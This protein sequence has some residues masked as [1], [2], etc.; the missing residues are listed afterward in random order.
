MRQW[1]HLPRFLSPK[2]TLLL[3]G[4][5]VVA[6]ASIIILVGGVL[7]SH[8]MDLPAAGG[9]YT[10]ALVGSPQYINP[11]YAGSNDVDADLTRLI[12]SGLMRP[13]EQ[14]GLTPDLAETVVISEDG[15]TYTLTIRDNARFHNG[16]EVLARDVLFTIEAIQNPQYRSPLAV[17]FQGVAVSQVD[18]KTIAFQ[19]E[20]PFA[21]FLSTL[22][23]GILP[24]TLWGEI[25]A[26]NAP[27]AERN[28]EPVGSGPYQFAK[29]SKD[30]KGNILS[31]TLERNEHYYSTPALIDELTFKFYSDA[32]SAV[33]A[34]DSHYVE[35]IG[36]VPPELQEQVEKDRSVTLYHPT[37]PR[38]TILFFNQEKRAELKKLDLRRAIAL[39]IDKQAIINDVL[40]G[41]AKVIDGPILSGMIGYHPDIAKISQNID[42]ANTLLDTLGYLRPEGSAYRQTKKDSTDSPLSFTLTTVQSPEFVRAAEMIRDQLAIIGIYVEIVSIP[43]EVFVADVLA[44][45]SYELLLSGV[46]LGLDPDPYPFWHS[47]QTRNG[48]LNLALYGN[49]KADTLLEEARGLTNP[50]ERAAKYREFQ[51]LLAQ[52]I[53]AIFLYQAS[54]AH[55]VSTRVKN[56]DLAHI[57]TPA[58]RFANV[59]EWYIKTKK[60]LR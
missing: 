33:E 47:S 59:A 10:E 9:T 20:E 4:A 52:D 23:L 30:K 56:V 12:Y 44:P 14:G 43:Q 41:N 36:Y 48:G 55:A 49:R 7:S 25:D 3:R 37:I 45:H 21:P 39:A 53:P 38:E 31:Y 11:L 57:S 42:E 35:G 19:L 60:T 15:L 1:R 40:S 46:L 8:R 27:L 54:Y 28:L 50:E 58:D 22:T 34:L 32:G 17:S 13:D 6:I 2:E 18:E 24:E 26:R 5:S 29:F 51:D 16:D